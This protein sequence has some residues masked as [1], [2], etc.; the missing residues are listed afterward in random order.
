MYLYSRQSGRPVKM[1]EPEDDEYVVVDAYN[2]TDGFLVNDDEPLE[3]V[4]D[5]A[6]ED[7]DEDALEYVSDNK[8]QYIRVKARQVM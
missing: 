5:E 3:Y 7:D 6:M 8:S 1:A 4:D 2:D